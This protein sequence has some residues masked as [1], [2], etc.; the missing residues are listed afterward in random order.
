M[1]SDVLA[2][3][4]LLQVYPDA[5]QMSDGGVHYIFFPELRFVSGAETFAMKALQI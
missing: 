5:Q 1:N 4:E 2:F 3:Y